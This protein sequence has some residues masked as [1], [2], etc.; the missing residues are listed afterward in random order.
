M[1]KK[2][3]D[4]FSRVMIRPLIYEGLSRFLCALCISLVLDR[5]IKSDANIRMYAF[6]AF[7]LIFLIAGWVVYLRLDGVH[8][9]VL[10][11]FKVTIHKKPT[12]SYGDLIDYV[13][14]KPELVQFEDLEDDEQDTVRL[15][16][17]FVCCVLCVICS[18]F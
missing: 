4:R 3:K 10:S 15:I 12:R 6:S 16:S 18:L 13:D 11:D 1:K 8:I 7:A 5:L 2:L 17:D 9:P 14:E